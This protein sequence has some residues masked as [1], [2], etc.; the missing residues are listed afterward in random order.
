MSQY[1]DCH[2]AFHSTSSTDNTLP[3]YTGGIDGDWVSGHSFRNQHSPSLPQSTMLSACQSECSCKNFNWR[4]RYLPII[5]RH[6]A[7]P[8]SRN[9]DVPKACP[10][11]TAHPDQWTSL[12]QASSGLWSIVALVIRT[13]AHRS[14]I[15]GTVVPGSVRGRVN[16]LS[17]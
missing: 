13:V 15:T 2:L 3:P 17:T 8:Q 6:I 4:S 16:R 11:R 1:G 10:R 7:I 5:S 12:V 9:R 14:I